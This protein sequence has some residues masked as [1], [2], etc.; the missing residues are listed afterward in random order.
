MKYQLLLIALLFILPFCNSEV[1]REKLKT[2]GNNTDS[3][4]SDTIKFSSLKYNLYRDQLGNIGFKTIDN[5]D[6]RNPIDRF[7]TTVWDANPNDSNNDGG[8]MEMKD[9]IDTA[10]FVELEGI[11]Y[12]DKNHFYVYNQMSDGGTFAVINNIDVKTFVVIHPLYAKDKNQIYY[13]SSIIK[14]ADPK[15]FKPLLKAPDSLTWYT[16]K[17]KNHFYYFGAIVNPEDI[18]LNKDN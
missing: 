3:S 10:S 5:S 16:A 15:S 17:D 7:V 11:Y 14:E 12:K 13:G 6:P 4:K 18:Q 1:K 8:K 9:V 2:P